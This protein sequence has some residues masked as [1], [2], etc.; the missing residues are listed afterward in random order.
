MYIKSVNNDEQRYESPGLGAP[1]ILSRS[2]ERTSA[3]FETKV[4]S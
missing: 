2:T 3:K 4:T 1:R